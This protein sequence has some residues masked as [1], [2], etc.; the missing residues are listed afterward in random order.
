VE[1]RMARRE[2]ARA[3]D[4]SPD[5]A[6][7]PGGGDMYGD[8]SFAAARDRQAASVSNDMGVL[9]FNAAIIAVDVCPVRVGPFTS[10]KGKPVDVTFLAGSLWSQQGPRC[11]NCQLS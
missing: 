5:I 11:W 8:D 4:A 3:R 7:V 6:N 9:N 1:K 10:H 2:D